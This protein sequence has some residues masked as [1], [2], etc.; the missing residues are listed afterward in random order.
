MGQQPNVPLRIEHLPRRTGHPSY[1]DR[2][3]PDRPGDMTSPSEVRWGGAF[4]TTGPDAG[5]AERLVAARKTEALAGETVDDVRRAVMVLAAARAA[6][7][8]RAPMLD[9]IEAGEAAL[10]VGAHNPAWRLR[11]TVG[12][13]HSRHAPQ[14]LIT[15]TDLT[16]LAAPVETIRR[17]TAEAKRVIRTVS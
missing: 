8:G 6:R 11:W 12:M 3:S 1:P 15:A 14:R 16:A 10:G 7:L 13:A 4:G 5:Y 17:R 2:W 9:D